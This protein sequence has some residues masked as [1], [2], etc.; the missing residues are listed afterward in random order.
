MIYHT[1]EKP[2]KGYYKCTLCGHE[3]EIEDETEMLSPCFNCNCITF[4]KRLFNINSYIKN[5]LKIIEAFSF[6]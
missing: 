4:T 2:N 5:K 6:Y 1:G 3:I